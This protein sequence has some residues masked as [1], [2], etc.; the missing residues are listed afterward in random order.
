MNKIQKIAKKITAGGGAGIDFQITD[1]DGKIVLEAE[2]TPNNYIIDV[3]SNNFEAKKFDADG[4]MDG[5]QNV[6]AKK[7]FDNFDVSK[8]IE[9][10]K[11]MINDLVNQNKD[12]EDFIFDLENGIRFDLT[13]RESEHSVLFGGYIRGDLNKGSIV[14][15]KVDFDIDSDAL[16]LHEG[17]TNEIYG[18]LSQEGEYWYEDVFKYCGDDEEDYDIHFQDCKDNYG[19]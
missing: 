9:D 4:Y 16:W 2:G 17:I 3:I 7:V 19:I 1:A 6:N 14:P 13:F 8:I 12:D 15:F 10:A 5:M 18:V 11:E